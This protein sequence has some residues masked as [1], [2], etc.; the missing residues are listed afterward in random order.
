MQTIDTINVIGFSAMGANFKVQVEFWQDDSTFLGADFINIPKSSVASGSNWRALL[1]AAAN[2]YCDNA[3]FTH[4]AHLW[5]SFDGE[6]GT[7]AY[8]SYEAIVTQTGTSA[9]TATLGNSD[10]GATTFTWARTAT[11]IYT[12]TAS[13]AIFT[14]GKTAAIISPASSPINNISAVAT[15]TTVITFT[16]S[17][18]NLLALGV[19]NADALLSKTLVE[20]RVYA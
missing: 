10:F 17:T 12:L 16:T 6:A 19:G 4:P 13:A 9:P 3:G 1:A 7:K 11:G 14:T 5:V 8:S 2:A 20:I 15:S 18:L